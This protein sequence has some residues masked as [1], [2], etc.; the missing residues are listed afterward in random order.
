MPHENERMLRI[1]YAPAEYTHP[2]HLPEI[3]QNENAWEDVL[4]N[5]WLVS[6]YQLKDLPAQWEAADTSSLLIINHWAH[7]PTTARLIG[8]YI[9]RN[10]LLSQCAALMSDP[11]LLAFISLPLTHHVSSVNTHQNVDI[12]A[13]GVAFILS[14]I[15]LFPLALKERLLLSFPVGINPPQLLITRTPDHFNLL[16]MA[17]NYANHYQ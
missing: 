17:V 1:L 11:R 5:Y 9:L 12:S 7:M 2:T 10:Q 8:G 3:F 16:Q 6:H 13:W 4:V 14:Q 15:P